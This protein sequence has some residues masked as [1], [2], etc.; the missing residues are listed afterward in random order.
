MFDELAREPAIG[1]A[2]ALRR[3]MV[4]MIQGGEPFSHPSAWAPFVVVG[5]GG[6]D[7]GTAPGAGRIAGS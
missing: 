7:R 5:K 4:G 3:V 1:G 2:E 6:R